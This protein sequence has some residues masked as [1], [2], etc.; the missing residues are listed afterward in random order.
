MKFYMFTLIRKQFKIFRSIIKCIPISK[1]K[2]AFS[3]QMRKRLSFQD[4]LTANFR[5]K[6]SVPSFAILII[7]FILVMSISNT[8]SARLPTQEQLNKYCIAVILKVDYDVHYFC[9]PTIVNFDDT[10][11]TVKYGKNLSKQN[12]IPKDEIVNFED[13]IA[14]YEQLRKDYK[15]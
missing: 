12:F 5:H 2:T 13:A 1:I 14:K 8:A 9:I 7:A 3:L 15:W 4:L 11:L 6:K 10:G